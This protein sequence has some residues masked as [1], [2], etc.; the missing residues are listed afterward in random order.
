M[1]VRAVIEFEFHESVKDIGVD[2]ILNAMNESKSN[3][4]NKI[5]SFEVIK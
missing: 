1:K 4:F 2:D 3:E 5:V